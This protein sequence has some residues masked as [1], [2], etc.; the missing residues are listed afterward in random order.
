M[1]KDLIEQRIIKFVNKEIGS[2]FKKL[3]RNTV[4]IENYKT[5]IEHLKQN[6]RSHAVVY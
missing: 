4:L 5:S 6:V 3:H 2:D 1:S